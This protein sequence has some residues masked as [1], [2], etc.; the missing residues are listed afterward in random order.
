MTSDF[1]TVAHTLTLLEK[2]N[3]NTLRINVQSEN[4]NNCNN[5]NTAKER[6]ATCDSSSNN[7]LNADTTKKMP[8]AEVA[9]SMQD[10]ETGGV[11]NPSNV[12][13]MHTCVLPPP[14]DTLFYIGGVNG[15]HL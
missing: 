8:T 15:A 11:G 7:T 1:Q 10:V 2:Y 12:Y 6:S 13:K 14:K 4:A 9:S 5:N 3:M